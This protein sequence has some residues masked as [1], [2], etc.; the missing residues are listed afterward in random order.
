MIVCENVKETEKVEK[1]GAYQMLEARPEIVLSFP[2][3][4]VTCR[5]SNKRSDERGGKREEAKECEVFAVLCAVIDG[6]ES[7]KED[8]VIS[9]LNIEPCW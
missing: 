3:K 2:W 4:S 5:N 9:Q 7:S 8:F 6:F 1:V